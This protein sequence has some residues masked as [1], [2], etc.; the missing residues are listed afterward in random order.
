VGS[1]VSSLIPEQFQQPNT[2]RKMV[3]EANNK[4]LFFFI[5]ERVELGVDFFVRNQPLTMF[6]LLVQLISGSNTGNGY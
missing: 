1:C 6:K 4:G 3:M 5:K 2:A